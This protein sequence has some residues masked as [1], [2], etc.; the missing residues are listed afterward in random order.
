MARGTK[1]MSR[2]MYKIT[3]EMATGGRRKANFEVFTEF[4][5]ARI[6]RQRN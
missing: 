6:I 5:D 2:Q 1:A 4:R 3:K